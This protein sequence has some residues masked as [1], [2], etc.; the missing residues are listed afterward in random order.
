MQDDY[1]SL[2]NNPNLKFSETKYTNVPK[3]FKP[4]T[5][6]EFSGTK[7]VFFA[8]EV[9]QVFISLIPNGRNYSATQII[10]FRNSQDKYKEFDSLKTS[11]KPYAKEISEFEKSPFGNIPK[12]IKHFQM[13]LKDE[14]GGGIIELIVS[15]PYDTLS[16]R[17]DT[18]K[19][20]PLQ[21]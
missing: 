5:A 15:P 21:K 13:K 20:I 4:F 12:I 17:Y 11:L 3:E 9:S 19:T 1:T 6:Y 14:F 2:M 10:K 7:N 8:S 16:I 18:K